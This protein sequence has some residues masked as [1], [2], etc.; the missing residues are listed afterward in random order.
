MTAI[1]LRLCAVAMLL[2]PLVAACPSNQGEPTV[3]TMDVR[4]FRV[5]D[6]IEGWHETEGSYSEFDAS[7][8]SEL[9][10]GGAQPHVDKGL[11]D[12]F[13]QALHSDATRE[14]EVYVEKFDAASGARLMFEFQLDMLGETI[15]LRSYPTT[16]AV[17]GRV[18][19]GAMV[20]AHWD[21]FYFALTLTNYAASEV[22]VEATIVDDAEIF[23]GHYHE[24]VSL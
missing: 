21:R 5:V 24:L 19:G 12:G 6:Q 23:L 7:N 15:G 1:S 2:G 14:L 22:D 9:I 16:T 4:T 8:L 17:A 13:T 10:D 11:V 3:E 18:L 20:Y